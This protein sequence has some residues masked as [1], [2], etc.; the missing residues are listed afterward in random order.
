LFDAGPLLKVTKGGTGVGTS[1]G[2]GN[3]VLSTS[4]TLVTP[5]LGTPTSA[6]LTNATGLP[7]STGVSGLGT[8]VATFLA[9]PSSANLAAALTD[10]TGSGANVFATSP[11]L[12][13]PILGTPTSATLTNATGLPLS[14]GVTGT[15]PVANGGTGLTTTPANGALDIGNGTGFTRGTLTAGSNIT[16]T[17][18]SGGISIAATGGT[19]AGSNTQVQFNNAGAFGASA[20]LTYD[21][22]TLTSTSATTSGI[23][24]NSTTDGRANIV[25]KSGGTQ[26]G[27]VGLSGATLGTSATDIGLFADSVN[28]SIKFFTNATS[29]NASTINRYGLGIGAAVPSSGIGIAFPASQSASSDA[30]TLDD[31]EE[32][33]WTPA[34]SFTGGNGTRTDTVTGKYTKIGDMVYANFDIAITKGTASGNLSVTG[35]PFARGGQDNRGGGVMFTYINMTALTN[36]LIAYIGDN[37]SSFTF[38]NGPA[39]SNITASGNLSSVSQF[40]GTVI[41][42]V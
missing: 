19:P 2:S 4:P 8:G 12:V 30:N 31:Y 27:V 15:L 11:T 23:A 7:I 21:G 40:I 42:K 9:T 32:G 33:S 13:T 34:S 25:F 37:Q 28:G 14:T 36:G 41:Y 38:F 3:N 6:T 17:N 24:L 5:I 1:T 35:L 18:S 20:N 16:I 22:T 26:Y 39:L 10:E 29:S